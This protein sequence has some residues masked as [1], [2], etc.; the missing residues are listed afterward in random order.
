MRLLVCGGRNFSDYDLLK[1]TID[2]IEG[3]ATLA[4][5]GARGADS[6]AGTYALARGWDVRVFQA[7]WKT[8]GKAA[9]PKRNQRMLDEFHPEMVVAFPG[10]AGTAD[11]IKRAKKA[12]VFIQRVS[13][14]SKKIFA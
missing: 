7:D 4:H 14:G 9:G 6:M 3:Q 10:G 11:M 5:G 8:F 1:E 13:R 12:G 2:K